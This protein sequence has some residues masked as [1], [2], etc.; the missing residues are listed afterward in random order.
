MN[1]L[2]VAVLAGG[3]SSEREISKLSG[4]MVA[5]GLKTLGYKVKEYDPKTD[6]KKIIAEVKNIDV[7]FPALHGRYGEDGTIQGFLELLG[8]SYV[9]SGVLASALAMDKVK[10][11][12]IYKNEGLPIPKG[13]VYS[14]GDDAHRIT[15][16]VGLPCVVKP[17]A[18]GSSF[19]ITIVKEEKGLVKAINEAIKFDAQVLI[20]EYIPGDEITVGVVGNDSLIAL[21]VVLIKLKHEF[22]NYEAKYSGETDEIVPA[23][24]DEGMAK[25]AKE[26]ALVAHKALGCRG[27]SRT[28]MIVKEKEIYLLE[29]NTMPGMTKESLLPKA[30]KAAGMSF[31]QLVQRL[32][33]LALE[34]WDGK[35]NNQ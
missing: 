21:P 32:I 10:T 7:V 18:D 24:I 19:G 9:G 13:I 1:K 11:R 35:K 17:V 2:R 27:L 23:P 31:N 30:A 33:E 5:E 15:S 25:R 34:E 16:E 29:T 3:K 6:L 12:E 26:Y 22:F 28:D 14:F 8:L 4:K 20:E